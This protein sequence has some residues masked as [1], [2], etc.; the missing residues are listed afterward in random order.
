MRG[1]ELAGG[2]SLAGAIAVL[3]ALAL[4]AFL[5]GALL[6][7]RRRGPAA[8]LAAG[9]LYALAAA[10][11]ALAVLRPSAVTTSDRETP[12]RVVV[13]VDRSASMRE[14]DLPAGIA[15][16]RLAAD[17]VRE[18]SPLR[19]ELERRARPVYLAFDSRVRGVEPAALAAPPAGSAT[20]LVGGLAGALASPGAGPLAGVVLITDGRVTRG[21]PL[22]LRLRELA[23]RKVPVWVVGAGQERA[24][25][26]PRLAVADFELPETAVI[27]ETLAADASL[28]ALG[29]AGRKVLV[30]LL[31]DG[32]ETARRELAAGSDDVRLPVRFGFAAKARGVHRLEIAARTL[33]PAPAPAARSSRYL[34]VRGR[35]LRALYAE[36]RLGWGYRALAGALRSA[37]GSEVELWTGF[38]RGRDQKLKLSGRLERLDAVILGDLPAGRLGRGELAALARAVREDGLGLLFA[39]GPERAASYA[40]TPLEGLLP[41]GL[42]YAKVAAGRRRVE[43]AAGAR[44]A[45]PLRLDRSGEV[46]H[47]LWKSL[48]ETRAGWK[49]GAPR[50]GAEVWLRAGTDPVLIAWP[51]GQGRAALLAWPDHWRW[52]RSGPA[53]AE[54]HRRLFARLAAWLAGRDEGGGGK[55][56]LSMTRYRL[57]SGEQVSLL[58]RLLQAPPDGA[59]VALRAEIGPAKGKARRPQGTRLAPVAPGRYRATVR[60]GDPGEYRVKV[61]ARAP[62]ADWAEAELVFTVEGSDLEME[63]PSPDFSALR[64]LAAS[65]GGGFLGPAEAERLP[66]IVARRLPAPR[67]RTR[68]TQ[69]SLWDHPAL[70]ALA[71][72]ASCAAWLMLRGGAGE[73]KK[74][75]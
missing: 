30:R 11:L 44:R 52:S 59:R 32:A 69:R 31:V 23:R 35:P 65:S 67:R 72:L 27:G 63:D 60:A 21:P 47:R 42:K 53:G 45:P 33:G 29:L 64:R 62:G 41:A 54:G 55:L 75:S 9:A 14:A 46:D 36:A 43:L 70:L 37:P 13:L 74:P 17:L 18:G 61:I 56:A 48:P 8:R 6:A 20:D 16:Y 66:G 28:R 2:L 12:P 34:V 1:L 39:A 73:E 71:L 68:R 22:G 50:P 19:L 49:P 40:G 3:A 26:R 51:A 5:G 58:A 10:C 25:A 15:R 38:V 24:A 7:A 57:T 4:A